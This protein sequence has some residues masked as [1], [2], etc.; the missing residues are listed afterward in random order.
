MS[1]TALAAAAGKRCV[2]CGVGLED[3]LQ[4][5][6]GLCSDCAQRPEGRRRLATLN[7]RP[8]QAG[9]PRPFTPADKSLIRSVHTL[10]PVQDLL[11]LLNIRLIAD[12][13]ADAVR[14]SMAQLQAEISAIAKPAAAG[15]W[16]SLRRILADARRSGV[17]DQATPQVIDDFAAVYQL[18]PA[19]HMHLKD[20]IRSAKGAR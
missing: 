14:Y 11:R 4:V 18:S 5:I 7:T 2:L 20:V 17:L 16:S 13:G 15:D 3:E 12:L 1:R 9:T 6:R 10:M 8:P 19:Q